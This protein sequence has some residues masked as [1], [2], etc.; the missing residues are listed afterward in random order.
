[1]YVPS[2]CSIISP[3]L[4]IVRLICIAFVLAILIGMERYLIVVLICIYLMTSEW[5]SLACWFPI[6]TSFFGEVPIHFLCSLFFS[7]WVVF[8]IVEFW[9]F[10]V[11]SR[12]QIFYWLC[13]LGIFSPS[14]HLSFHSLHIVFHWADIFISM[15]SILS[16]FFCMLHAFVS[17]NSLPYICTWRFSLIISPETFILFILLWNVVT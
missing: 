9:E 12:W 11:Y 6:G 1:M 4:G 10:F 16:I 5:A 15:K 17:K 13:D 8:L 3:V 14:L 7:P 2:S